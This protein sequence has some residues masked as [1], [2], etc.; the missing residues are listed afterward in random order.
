MNPEANPVR[1][2]GKR[3]LWCGHYGSCLDNAARKLWR[4]W[5]CSQC[6][7]QSDTSLG[8]DSIQTR[9]EFDGYHKIA[10]GVVRGVM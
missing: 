9:S 5:D 1:Q 8:V 6:G 7:H 10:E 3:N 2:K 4:D